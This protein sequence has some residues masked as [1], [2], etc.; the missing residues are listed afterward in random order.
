M[1]RRSEPCDSTDSDEFAPLTSSRIDEE[2]HLV[3]DMLMRIRHHSGLRFGS[4]R[5]G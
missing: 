2:H 4:R 1:K 3:V 5:Y